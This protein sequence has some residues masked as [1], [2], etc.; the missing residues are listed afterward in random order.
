V[1]RANL[2]SVALKL[3][4]SS[5]AA[6]DDQTPGVLSARQEDER[7]LGIVQRIQKGEATLGHVR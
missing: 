7:L 1:I 2:D 5:F 3:A 4:G 6:G